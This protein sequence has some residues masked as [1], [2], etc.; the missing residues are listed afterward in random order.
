MDGADDETVS[1]AGSAD[2]S[3][4]SGGQSANALSSAS[5][6]ED[7]GHQQRPSKRL[8]R[9]MNPDEKAKANRWD[10]VTQ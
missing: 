3:T 2:S 4:R 8:K 5:E 7:A 9:D 6:A 1:I 10:D